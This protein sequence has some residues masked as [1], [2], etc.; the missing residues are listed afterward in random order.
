MAQP[1][2]EEQVGGD[3]PYENLLVSI[4]EGIVGFFTKGTVTLGEL[5]KD[6]AGTFDL[7]RSVT[8]SPTR[9]IVQSHTDADGA[10]TYSEMVVG[11]GVNVT[12]DMSGTRYGSG[13][14]FT[15]PGHVPPAAP[16]APSEP[17]APAAP[18]QG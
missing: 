16:G 9:R 4:V 7:N 10:S 17:E 12:E 15:H 13:M 11:P 18:E 3:Q 5:F 6:A 8:I 14:P 1:N 2:N